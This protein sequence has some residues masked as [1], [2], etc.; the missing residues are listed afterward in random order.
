MKKAPKFKKCSPY[1]YWIPT[2]S[3]VVDIWSA[4]A[5][6]LRK[7]GTSSLDRSQSSRECGTS[8]TNKQ[9]QIGIGNVSSFNKIAVRED[10]FLVE[11]LKKLV[12]YVC[13]DICL[14]T[15]SD[16][17]IST[18]LLARTDWLEAKPKKSV[19]FELLTARPWLR[20]TYLWKYHNL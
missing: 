10:R 20:H 17:T 13:S 5:T 16:A 7:L 12:V 18:Y 15:V 19:Q 1:E 6:R 14:F 3:L 8:V 9:K 11:I 4:T 2:A